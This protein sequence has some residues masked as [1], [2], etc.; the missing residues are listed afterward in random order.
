MLT[1]SNYWTV[2]FE[3]INNLFFNKYFYKICSC[4]KNLVCNSNAS[5][6]SSDRQTS[7]LERYYITLRSLYTNG[8]S[9]NLNKSMQQIL[10]RCHMNLSKSV[11]YKLLMFGSKLKS[12]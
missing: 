2:K 12:K 3:F 1:R 10:G 7:T 8:Y 9:L 5:L 4:R 6:L 11:N